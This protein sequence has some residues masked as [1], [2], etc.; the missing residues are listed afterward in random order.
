MVHVVNTE[1]EPYPRIL[2]GHGEPYFILISLYTSGMDNTDLLV[3]A[4]VV[5]VVLYLLRSEIGSEVV[6]AKSKIDGRWYL[7]RN[8]PN[9]MEAANLLARLNQILTGTI[10]GLARRNG[11]RHPAVLRLRARYDP[12]SLSES[13]ETSKY[14]TSYSVNK[15]EKIVMCLRSRED[16]T[17]L[18]DINTLAYVALHELA[19]VMT[20][21]VGHTP[22]FWDN[23]RELLNVA[24]ED[25][26]YRAVDYR[27]HPEKYCGVTIQSTVLSGASVGGPDESTADTIKAATRA[28]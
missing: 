7:V 11:N 13:S 8:L 26:L 3:F 28:A 14:Y 4:C 17:K 5:I 16:E 19:H 22:A 10:D 2:Y 15:G 1:S 9:H 12:G 18:A 24:V 6:R 20:E 21:E 25:G 27:A 23:F